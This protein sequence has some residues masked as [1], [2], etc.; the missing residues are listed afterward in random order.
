MRTF[1]ICVSLAMAALMANSA[2]AQTSP[3]PAS[4]TQQ[5]LAQAAREQKF[6]FIMFYKQNDANAQS[7][8]KILSE[9]VAKR[10]DRAVDL[11]FHFDCFRTTC[12]L[13]H[14][15]HKF[16]KRAQR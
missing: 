1:N 11:R 6:T 9:G 12:E 3:A 2:F 13:C 5:L 7:V 15:V 4:K 8:A 16:I 10:G 14:E